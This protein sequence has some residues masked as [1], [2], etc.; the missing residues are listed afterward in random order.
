MQTVLFRR[1]RG[2]DF[3]CG[4]CVLRG[5]RIRSLVLLLVL[6]CCG[7]GGLRGSLFAP[8]PPDATRYSTAS[9]EEGVV[10]G[11]AA[12]DAAALLVAYLR[13]RGDDPKPDAA[14][15]G[16]AAWILQGAYAGENRLDGRAIEAAAQR[17]GYAG[18]ILGATISSLD[19][20]DS[21]VRIEQIVA[22][23]PA[24][25]RVTR[26][27]VRGVPGRNVAIVLGALEV[28][29][30]P[31]PRAV[32]L[33]G[34]VALSGAVSERYDRAS[35][36]VRDPSG[37]V[38]ELPQPGRKVQATLRLETRGV[39]QVEVMGYG[40][41]GPVVLM[42]VPIRV[43]QA[44][45]AAALRGKAPD[46][47]L[48]TEQAEARLLTLLNDARGE[49]R[50]SA[51]AADDE[52]RSI[53]LGHSRDMAKHHFFSHVSPTTGTLSDRVARAGAR[54]S[55]GAE[56]VA[57]ELTPEGAHLGLM[58]SPAHRAGMLDADFTH[59]GIGVAFRQTE[60]GQRALLATLVLARRPPPEAARKSAAEVFEAIQRL[61]EASN[62]SPAGS[63]PL[64]SALATAGI[65]AL[66]E[67][68]NDDRERT[69][70]TAQIEL[71]QH[72][73]M[74]RRGAP[75]CHVVFQMIELRQLTEW[76]TLVHPNLASIG[77]AV[78]ALTDPRGPSLAVALVLESKP[79]KPLPC[80]S[81]KP[82]SSAT[83]APA[84][85]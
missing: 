46:P 3:R 31:F 2:L 25:R 7:C 27:G 74:S 85:E 58:Q 38:R 65:R 16:A 29:L 68:S 83:T 70:A 50:L 82:A 6:L 34:E 79:G 33:G 12:Q 11:E 48:T 24:N 28:E 53:A 22:Q 42:N 13:E 20:H 76:A 32:E 14:L 59:V 69:F 43:G 30:A 47:N 71:A 41:A 66:K 17:F 21:V 35:V 77:V 5:V 8:L 61:R 37:Q 75:V 1:W 40:E 73:A 26:Y 39:H 56:C 45:S 51:L 44:E 80:H 72:V 19:S 36:F 54:V 10:G 49:H 55:K 52:L 60:T 67:R 4:A 64:L 18:L 81:V 62:V 57:L 63:D 23:V 78:H 15:A 84:S 9:T